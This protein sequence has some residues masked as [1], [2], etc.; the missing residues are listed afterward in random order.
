MTQITKLLKSTVVKLS[1]IFSREDNLIGKDKRLL[2]AHKTVALFGLGGVGSFTAEALARA[3]VGKLVI[4]DGDKVDVT[5]INRQLYALNST[6]GKLKTDV[7]YDRLKDINPNIEVEKFPV[8][9]SAETLRLFDFQ[10]YDYVVDCVDTVTAKILLCEASKSAYKPVIACLGTGNKLNPTAFK[11]GDIYQT[12]VCP[13]AKVIRRE[14]RKRNI[15]SLKTVYSEEE[16]ISP[17]GDKR[18]PASI[19]FVPPVA[20]F[21][22]ASEVIKDLIQSK[23]EVNE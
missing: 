21:I 9:F 18:V 20:G 19:S 15:E 5:N 16:P 8:Y 3:G 4:C 22:I 1:D 13:L 23:G 17:L 12:K 11:V 7:A 2:L 14:L 6:V 10:S